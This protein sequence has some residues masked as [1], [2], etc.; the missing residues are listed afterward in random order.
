[1]DKFLHLGCRTTNIFES[2]LGKLK[3]C[4]RSSV[5]DLASCW[6]E[7]NKMLANQLGEIQGSFGRSIIVNEHKYKR[8]KLFSEL[9]GCWFIVYWF[10]MH[11]FMS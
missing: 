8:H 10:V 5:E 1:M 4:L 3:S 9:E 2:T 7:I 11:L 6:D